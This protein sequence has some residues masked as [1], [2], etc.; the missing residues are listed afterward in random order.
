M[1][2]IT[3]SQQEAQISSHRIGNQL[4]G[5][6]GKS[7]FRRQVSAKLG[8]IL[9]VC[10]ITHLLFASCLGQLPRAGR[11]L[12]GYTWVSFLPP[13]ATLLASGGGGGGGGGQEKKVCPL[14]LTSSE[15]DAAPPLCRVFS[16]FP[17]FSFK[18][19]PKN[20]LF[21]HSGG[22]DEIKSLCSV[23]PMPGISFCSI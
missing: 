23:H 17:H 21:W 12:L 13:R 11:R 4:R 20:R 19:F 16:F 3:S 5:E 7:F 15:T 22:E 10:L 9:F 14:T 6:G 1:P 18:R 2:C 8:S